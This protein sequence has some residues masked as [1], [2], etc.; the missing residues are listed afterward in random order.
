MGATNTVTYGGGLTLAAPK[1]AMIGKSNT[2]A[3]RSK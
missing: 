3:A 1:V 2:V